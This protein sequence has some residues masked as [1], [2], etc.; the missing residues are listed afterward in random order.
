VSPYVALVIPVED[1]IQNLVDLAVTVGIDV[2][3]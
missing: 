2:R 1:D 3:M